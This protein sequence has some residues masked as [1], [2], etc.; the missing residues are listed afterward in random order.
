MLRCYFSSRA[1]IKAFLSLTNVLK[2]KGGDQI[3]LHLQE[4]PKRVL[5]TYKTL[6]L[7]CHTNDIKEAIRLLE[8]ETGSHPRQ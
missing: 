5:R 8:G 7:F 6:D 2:S 4:T 3:L 1:G